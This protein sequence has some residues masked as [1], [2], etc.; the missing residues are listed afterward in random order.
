MSPD[1]CH[2]V[3][4][5]PRKR[6]GWLPKWFPFNEAGEVL[7]V[8]HRTTNQ[9][10]A[11]IC[12]AGVRQVLFSPQGNQLV[13]FRDDGLI[14]LY[15]FPFTKPWDQIAGTAFF[16]ASGAWLFAWGWTRWRESRNAVIRKPISSGVPDTPP[17]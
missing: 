3:Q 4:I 2:S 14:D 13:V 5:A 7:R 9:H 1:G 12:Y 10:L 16:M 8:A 15:D 17:R 6:P 11:E